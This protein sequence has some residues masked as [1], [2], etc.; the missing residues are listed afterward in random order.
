[1]MWS[2]AV[3]GSVSRNYD[4][5]F[6]TTSLTVNGTPVS[7]TYDSD[8]LLT[9]AG[10]IVLNHDPPQN[11]LLTS[12]TLGGETEQFSYNGFGELS[13]IT[14]TWNGAPLFQAQ[15]TRDLEGRVVRKTETT[16]GTANTVDYAYDPA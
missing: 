5:N 2:G 15:Y 16:T 11:G 7:F 4:A 3:A 9:K 12:T 8:G 1:M 10:D 6:R 13:S 14:A